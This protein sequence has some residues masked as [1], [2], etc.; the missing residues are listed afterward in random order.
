M[1]SEAHYFQVIIAG[2]RRYRGNITVDVQLSSVVPMATR[3]FDFVVVVQDVT[4]S[5]MR[6]EDLFTSRNYEAISFYANLLRELV[7]ENNFVQVKE[8]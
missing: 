6:R 8:G 2:P 3:K 7:T 4:F 5:N 1:T